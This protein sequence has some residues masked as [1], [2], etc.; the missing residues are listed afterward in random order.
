MPESVAETTFTRRKASHAHPRLL[1]ALE[2]NGF[3]PMTVT[4]QERTGTRLPSGGWSSPGDWTDV[5]GLVDIPARRGL[6]SSSE[7]RSTWG[8]SDQDVYT[9]ALN[10]YYPD[11]H[12]DMRAVTSDGIE[13]D[14]RGAMHDSA[15]TMTTVVG[16]T[17]TPGSE[18]E[19]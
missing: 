6:L 10:G 18:G 12:G 16:R 9:L 8:R 5:L 3:Y 13:I 4:F 17:V 2:A 1:R 19:E 7:R 14:I 11:V 15:A